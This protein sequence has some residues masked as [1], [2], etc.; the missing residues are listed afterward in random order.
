MKIKIIFWVNILIVF[1]I[2]VHEIIFF[3]ID[4]KQ[5]YVEFFTRYV[6]Y[7][8]NIKKGVNLYTQDRIAQLRQDEYFFAN[9][10]AERKKIG[11]LDLSYLKKKYDKDVFKRLLNKN[12]YISGIQIEKK[13]IVNAIGKPFEGEGNFY[14]I[15]NVDKINY[16]Y[17]NFGYWNDIMVKA[18]YCDKTGFDDTDFYVL[19]LLK[20]EDGGYLDTHYLF[21]LLFLKKNKCY[22]EDKIDGQINDVSNDIAAAEDNDKTFSDLY[23]ERIVFLYWAGHGNLIKKEWVDLVKINFHEEYG[24]TEKD[25]Y[26]FSGHVTGL[27]LLSLIYYVE[28]KTIQPFYNQ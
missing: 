15:K 26:S 6:E 1:V 7:Y 2:I 8:P 19:N 27:S 24:W 5:C 11:N 4:K 20:S 12:D 13:N 21:G 25:S 3:N 14:S 22:A 23:A 28:G 18:I 17:E 9:E 10:I 16:D